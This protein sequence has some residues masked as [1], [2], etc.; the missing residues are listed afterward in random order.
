MKCDA[1]GNLYIT[2]YGKGTIV[3]LSQ[4]GKE[5][6]EIALKGKNCSNLVFGGKRGR[7][8]FVTLQDRKGIE[9][10]M[11]DLPGKK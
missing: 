1:A 10:F 2:R 7:E 6:R 11:N 9:K 5:V 8:V 3:V 4:E